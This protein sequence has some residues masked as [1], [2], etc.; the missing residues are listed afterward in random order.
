M[1]NTSQ[2]TAFE[3]ELC[4]RLAKEGFW[5]M[6]VPRALDGSQPFDVVAGRNGRIYA[7]ECKVCARDYFQFSRI[8]P[9][10]ETSLHRFMCC[11]N[12][13]NAF[14]AFKRKD[15]SIWFTQASEIMQEHTLR[16]TAG[17]TAGREYIDAW[18]WRHKQ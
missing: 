16:K 4:E 6:Q 18:I 13:S 8:E 10:Q 14:F 3:K 1:G 15:G 2:G 12:T 11:G 5:A 9:N 17:I 7:F